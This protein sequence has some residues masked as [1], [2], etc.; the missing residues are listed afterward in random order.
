MRLLF[1]TEY[2]PGADRV[3]TGGVETRA[4]QVARA[5]AERHDVT[6]VTSRRGHEPR[7][8]SEGGVRVLRVGPAYPYSNEGY[9]LK[10]LC[11]AVSAFLRALRV[12]ADVVEGTSFLTYVP[13]AL[14][15]LVKRI[16]RIATYHESWVGGHWIRNKGWWTGGLGELW[17]RLSLRLVWTRIISV[18][19]FT[20]G[21]LVA[22]GVPERLVEVVPNGIDP[23]QFD[24]GAPKDERPTI[25]CVSRLISTKRVDLLIRALPQVSEQIPDVRVQIVGAGAEDQALRAL[26]QSLGVAERITFLGRVA[27]HRE[28][29]KI[30][31]RAR[32][33]AL[34]SD[35]EGFG[36]VVL[37]AMASGVPVVCSDIPPLREVTAGQ[38]ALLFEPGDSDDLAEKLTLL[39]TD[40][41]VY[42]EKAREASERV[43]DFAWPVLILRIEGVYEEVV[44]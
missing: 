29:R 20:K 35:S 36:I 12:D 14:T 16:P 13:A 18:S 6:V 38:G 33:F 42:E 32:V 27:D 31:E 1:L 40:E 4:W 37:E 21:I 44:Q 41:R 10:R 34:P 25:A 26:A 30:I 11:W 24:P 5:L 23:S 17:E 8:A 2:Y 19:E 28:V 15:G 7:E 39:L 3:F 22:G 9:V 43:Q